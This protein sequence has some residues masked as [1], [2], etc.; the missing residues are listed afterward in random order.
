MHLFNN[1]PAEVVAETMCVSVSS[2]Y[3]Y[4]Q[5]YQAT[6]DVRPFAKRNGPSQELCEHEKTLLLDL[7]LAHPGIYLRELQQ[8]LYSRTLHWV[9]VSTIC[10]AMHRI[11]MTRQVIKHV[12]LQRS[13][14]K[15]AE[16]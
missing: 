10:R 5:R 2:I 9:D 11:G 15:R 4:S 12:A 1:V 3:R 14:L 13:E 8:E 16:Y 7:S 6:G